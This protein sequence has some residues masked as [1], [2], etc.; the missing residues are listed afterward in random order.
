MEYRCLSALLPSASTIVSLLS[1]LFPYLSLSS[2]LSLLSLPP[3]LFLLPSLSLS[4]LTS[5]S[6][7]QLSPL[8]SPS[9]LSPHLQD[10]VVMGTLTV[11]ENFSFSAALRLPTSVSQ[12]EKDTRVEQ[13]IQQLG[14]VKVADS[15]VQ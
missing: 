8:T 12:Q 1:P 3:P 14:L 13:L 2:P 6:P 15:K 4:P 11:R 10:D 9:P 5:L 7:P